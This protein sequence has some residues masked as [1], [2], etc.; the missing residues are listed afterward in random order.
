MDQKLFKVRNIN[1][2][3]YLF[4]LVTLILVLFTVHSSAHAQQ[5][6]LTDPSSFSPED[7]DPTRTV[8]IEPLNIIDNIYSVSAVSH[9]PSWLITTPDGHFLIDTSEAEFAP[10]IA[11]NIEKLGFDLEDVEY[12][13]TL[14]AH[15]DHVGGHAYMKEATGATV[16]AM[17]GD[18]HVMESGGETDFRERGRWPT[19]KVDRIITDMEKIQLG[20]TVLTPHLTAGHSKGCTTWSMVA[21]ENG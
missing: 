4:F 9:Y 15:R 17:E 14:H 16:M 12:L 3:L 20:D 2:N 7:D 21:E 13:L 1:N 8:P 6:M 19:V 5:L 11:N 18:A 10:G